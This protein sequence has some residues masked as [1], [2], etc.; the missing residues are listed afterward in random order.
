MKPNVFIDGGEMHL[1]RYLLGPE[2]IELPRDRGE[3]SKTSLIEAPYAPFSTGLQIGA[4]ATNLQVFATSKDFGNTRRSR[5]FG[6]G[7]L[8]S[9]GSEFH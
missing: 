1:G 7:K 3:A 9:E 4:T 2:A 6:A 8:P 5:S